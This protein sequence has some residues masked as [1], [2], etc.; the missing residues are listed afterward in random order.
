MVV[1][2]NQDGVIGFGTGKALEPEIAVDKVGC[3]LQACRFESQRLLDF[4]SRSRF[5]V[6]WVSEYQSVRTAGL[7]ESWVPSGWVLNAESKDAACLSLVSE[8]DHIGAVVL[9]APVL[10]LP[11]CGL[12]D[13]VRSKGLESPVLRRV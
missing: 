8:V 13:Q 9:V 4:G 3:T 5:C 10:N 11:R 7:S 2:G 12:A 1:V 6:S